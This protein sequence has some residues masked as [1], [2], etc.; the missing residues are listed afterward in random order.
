MPQSA[1]A[2]DRALRGAVE[3]SAPAGGA[4]VLAV[5]G[6]R[7]SMVLLDVA[8]R[9][10]PRA[11]AAVAVFDHGTGDFARAAADAVEAA[12]GSRGLECVR[13]SASGL[14]T[15]ESAWRDARWAFLNAVASARN[16][17]VATAHTRDDQVETVFI[18]ALRGSSVR[19]LAGLY[20]ESRVVRPLLELPRGTVA[21]YAV[22][23]GLSWVEDPGNLSRAHLRNRV[24]LDL[25][26][27]CEAVRPGFG[28]EL[29]D[30]SR[31]AG[32]WRTAVERSLE[33]LIVRCDGRS[34][35]VHAEALLA[36]DAAVRAVLWPAVAARAGIALDRRG[37]ARLAALGTGTRARRVPLAGGH[38]VV[39]RGRVF[40]VRAAAA[41]P[42]F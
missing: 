33:P 28:A 14:P 19:G 6:G 17:R 25:L 7:D 32:A 27:A 20:A 35:Y 23:R 40:E 11:I 1:N 30:L 13:G 8:H 3:A 31:R 39:R 29:L 12:A 24:R 18:R 34:V 16:A 2:L 37:I 15:R 9:W 5:S 4:L 10:S 22:S 21:D 36:H 42:G 41:E 26:P 38:E